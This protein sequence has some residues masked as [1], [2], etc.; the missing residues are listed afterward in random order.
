MMMGQELHYPVQA[1]RQLGRQHSK[2]LLLQLAL[3]AW[4]GASPDSKHM[5]SVWLDGW[6]I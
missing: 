5:R 1:G 6:A 3:A 2:C 4:F